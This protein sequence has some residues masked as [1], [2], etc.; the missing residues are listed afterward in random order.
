ML[1]LIALVA[2]SCARPRAEQR[3]PRTD[4][5]ADIARDRPERLVVPLA[6]AWVPVRST[7]Q[8]MFTLEEVAIERAKLPHAAAPP[9]HVEPSAPRPGGG[10]TLELPPPPAEPGEPP[11]TSEPEANGP[12]ARTLVPPIPRGAPGV[13]SGGSGI[14]PK[15]GWGR[16]TLDVRVDERGEVSDALLVETDADSLTVLAA[17]DAASRLTYHPALL[18]GRPVAVWTRQLFEVERGGPRILRGTRPKAGSGEPGGA[19]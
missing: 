17:L 8:G 10:A 11:A 4:P 16:V 5:A 2:L 18:G 9:P 15:H 6:G 14:R 12:D 3:A 7:G 19:P 13:V 1:A